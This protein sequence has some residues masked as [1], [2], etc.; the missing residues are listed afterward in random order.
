MYKLHKSASTEMWKTQFTFFFFQQKPLKWL[1]WEAKNSR[2]LKTTYHL[3]GRIRPRCQLLRMRVPHRVEA[4]A[5]RS[6]SH[7]ARNRVMFGGNRKLLVCPLFV[8]IFTRRSR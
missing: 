1:P 8:Y 7:M 3:M 2:L 6:G 5:R 4:A